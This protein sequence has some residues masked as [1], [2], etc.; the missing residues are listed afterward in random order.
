MSATTAAPSQEAEPRPAEGTTPA[1][2]IDTRSPKTAARD[3]FDVLKRIIQ[4]IGKDQLTLQA[5]AVAYNFIF[6]VAPLLIFIMSMAAAVSR[7]VN[8]NTDE[9]VQ[10][11]VTWLVERLPATTAEALRPVIE[12][13][14]EQSGGGIITVGALLALFGARGA[15]GALIVA[16]NAAYRVEETRNFVKRQLLAIGLTFAT[17]F[18]IILSIALFLV[19]GQIGTLVA[20]AVGLGSTWALV[21]NIARFPLILVILIVALAILYWA[22]PNSAIPLR[23]LSPGAVFAVVGWVVITLF[24]NT[25][26][27]YAGGYAESYGVL[28]GVLAFIFYL[29]LMSL[30]LLIGGELNAQLARRA[31]QADDATAT[32]TAASASPE[33]DPLDEGL[34]TAI[35]QARRSLAGNGEAALRVP[36]VTTPEQAER[37]RGRAVRGLAV[38]AA[39]ATA[40]L[41]AA[42][43]RRR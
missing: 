36:Y 4:S 11:V 10:N 15:M 31:P 39:T 27:R 5:S 37:G 26:F 3:V 8:P 33:V 38:G 17:G 2:A 23:W 18:G 29:F 24:V 6:A 12:G 16:L 21:W 28:G 32:E 30:V 43:V 14:L 42:V 35:R 41:L 7:A 19:G 34:R 13:A 20:D 40:G 1:D 22:G 25:Y 9:T